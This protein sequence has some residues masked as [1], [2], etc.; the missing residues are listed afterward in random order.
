MLEGKALHCLRTHQRS[1]RQ[2]AAGH[3]GYTA[4]A[5]AQGYAG[6]SRDV[7]RGSGNDT[8]GDLM[9]MVKTGGGKAMLKTVKGKP[10]TL[11]ENRSKLFIRARKIMS[12]K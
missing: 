10:L 2:V 8:A 1:I 4:E 3:G 5:E 12:L 9:K 6:E 7:S 11:S